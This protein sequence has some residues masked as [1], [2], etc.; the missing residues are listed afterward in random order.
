MHIFVLRYVILCWSYTTFTSNLLVVEQLLD[1]LWDQNWVT[2]RQKYAFV[3][4]ICKSQFFFNNGSLAFMFLINS[5]FVNQVH[6]FSVC[7]DPNYFYNFV[8]GLIDGLGAGSDV[9]DLVEIQD[10]SLR[11]LDQQFMLL[12]FL[13]LNM[14]SYRTVFIISILISNA[15]HSLDSNLKLWLYE[16]HWT[17]NLSIWMNMINY[18]VVSHNYDIWKLIPTYSLG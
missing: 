1:F 18:I 16:P 5:H 17:I 15:F 7:D 9:H 10:V 4:L 12:M 8:Q 13:F 2:W 3:L 6:A 14:V 11:F